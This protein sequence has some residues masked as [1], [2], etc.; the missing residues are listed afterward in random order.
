MDDIRLYYEV[1]GEGTPLVLIAGFSCDHT[2][3]SEVLQA[4][5]AKHKV[6]LLDNRGIGQTESP[7]KPYSIEIMSDDVMRLVKKLG[8]Q[9][10]IIIGQSMGSAMAQDI[11]KR[12]A[13]EINKIVL[14][15]TFSQISKI[16]EIA[17]DAVADLHRLNVPIS[18]RVQCITP[19]V[20]SN[21]FLSQPNQ[22]E[23]LIQLAEQNPYPQTL[24]GY[25][26]QLGALKNFNS[27]TWLHEIKTPALIIAG[28]EDVIAPLSGAEEVQKK[29]GNNTKLNI[30][31]GGHAS[32]IE[33]PQKVV[34]EIF[35]FIGV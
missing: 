14:M 2:F 19:W 30:I 8:F 24:I 18:Y 21:E 17:F 34:D 9:N 26:R 16:A 5:A 11:A 32:P 27:S 3:W 6:L 7:D 28:K 23:K 31:P 4:L 12:Y 35:K 25:E 10:P 15:N 29:I 1:H 22:L 20:F 13:K 33:Q